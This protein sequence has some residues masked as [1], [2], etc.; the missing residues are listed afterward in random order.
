[1]V[2]L[3]DLWLPILLAAVLVFLASFVLHMVLPIHRSDYRQLPDEENI[4]VA[5][6]T[7]RAVRGMYMFP[8]TH[9]KEMGTPE[10]QEKFRQ[11]PVGIV[12]LFNPGPPAM[13]KYLA[14]WFVFCVLVSFF[15]AYLTGRTVTPGTP[16]LEVF[17]VAGTTAFMA[18]G[19]GPVS[20][21]IWKGV[22]WAVVV[23]EV[24][25]GLIYGLMTA[26]AFGWLWAR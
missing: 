1:M 20:N 3:T 7:A 6:R 10:A 17:R 13:G 12:T 11:G 24:I 8:F 5:L 9:H 25:D 16:Y 14:Q 22:P 2:P 19:V 15:T 26:G 4:R 23:K 21:G 18:Y